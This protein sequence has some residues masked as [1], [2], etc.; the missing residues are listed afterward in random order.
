MSFLLVRISMYKRLS[1]VYFVYVWTYISDIDFDMY[2][3]MGFQHFTIDD[4]V[5]GCL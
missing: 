3:D 5:I 4:E 2:E 1:R